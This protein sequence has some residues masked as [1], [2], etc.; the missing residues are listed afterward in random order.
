MR[1]SS[2]F[3]AAISSRACA[4]LAHEVLG[5][6]AKVADPVHDARVLVLDAVEVVVAVDEVVEAVGVEDHRERVGLIRLVDLDEAL[7]KDLQRAAE[8][9]AKGVEA[10]RLGLEPGLGLGELLG[11]D[12]LAVAKRRDLAC[13]LVDLLRVPGELGRE[14][15]LL[16]THL[17]ELGL[18]RV[19][20]RFERLAKGGPAGQG[21]AGRGCGQQ[22]T[23]GFRGARRHDPEAKVAR[24]RPIASIP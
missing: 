4:D 19:A 10:G 11:D 18:L 7:G 14:D 13:E 20:L 21:D 23:Q 17:L 5:L 15:A 1:S 2:A 22:K 24:I 6:V 9:L 16:R 12:G 8:P 3:L